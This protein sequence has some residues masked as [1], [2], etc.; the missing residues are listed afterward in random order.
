MSKKAKS[1]Q[2]IRRVVLG[3]EYKVYSLNFIGSVPNMEELEVLICDKRP[4]ETELCEKHKVDKVVIFPTKIITGNYGV[5]ID[6][7]ME[8]ATLVD[9]KEKLLSE[10]EVTEEVA[11]EKTEDQV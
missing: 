4:S 11:E 7:F 2:V 8:M 3:R 6:K 5:P 10:S 9:K 1:E